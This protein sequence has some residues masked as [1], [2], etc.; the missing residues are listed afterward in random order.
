MSTMEAYRAELDRL[1]AE[2]AGNLQRLRTAKGDSY[3]QEDLAWDAKL[4]RT[5][6]GRYEQGRTDPSLSTL[7]ILADTLGCTLNDLAKG[8]SVPQ[9]R[10]PSPKAERRRAAGETREERQT[11][12]D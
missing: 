9:E 2:F 11:K 10:R 1:L 8:L 7:L 6:I 12:A 3:S 4:D 5:S